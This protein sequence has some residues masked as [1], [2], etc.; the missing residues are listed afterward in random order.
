MSAEMR[1]FELRGYKSGY[2]EYPFGFR[3]LVTVVVLV[4]LIA[5]TAVFLK[6]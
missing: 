2:K 5:V 6:A 1:G 4:L 3:D